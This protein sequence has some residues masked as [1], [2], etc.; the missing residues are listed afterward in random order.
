M[1]RQGSNLPDVKIKT[2]IRLLASTEMQIP[3]I[4]ERIGCSR[5]VIVSINRKHSVRL[6]EGKRNRW[7][8]AA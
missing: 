2:I 6:Y 7:K 1:G 5:S 8:M 4:A 3:E